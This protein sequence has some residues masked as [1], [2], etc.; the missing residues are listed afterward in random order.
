[1]PITASKDKAVIEYPLKLTEI[2][3][4][5]DDVLFFSKLKQKDK[6]EYGPK[7]YDPWKAFKDLEEKLDETKEELMK[8]PK[9]FFNVLTPEQ[10]EGFDE[11]TE[12]ERTSIATFALARMDDR[13]L[14]PQLKEL[15]IIIEKQAI[16]DLFKEKLNGWS[17]NFY[18][19]E[20]GNSLPCNGDTKKKLVD[21]LAIEEVMLPAI[22]YLFEQS[23]MMVGGIPFTS[24]RS[25]NGKKTRDRSRKK[26]NSNAKPVTSPVGQETEISLAK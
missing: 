8:D 4:F 20:D 5:E 26:R 23:D 21:D 18:V 15:S 16:I 6:L 24:R 13:I 14:T 2:E 22:I 12:E 19:D 11:L 7:I 9:R 10:T 3:G 25:I 1:M 17:E